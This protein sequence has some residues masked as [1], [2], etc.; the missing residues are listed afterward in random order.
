MENPGSSPAG[1]ALLTAGATIVEATQKQYTFNGAVA[2]VRVVPTVSWLNP[3]KRT[4]V[5]F[6]GSY[7]KITEDGYIS[8]G[9]F[10][11][12]TSIKSSIYHADAEQDWYFTPRVYFLAADGF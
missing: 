2:L 5:D 7:G 12:A 11:P 6:T 4:I 9:V 1:T 3:R 8:E 10:Y